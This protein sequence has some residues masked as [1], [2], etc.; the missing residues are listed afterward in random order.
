MANDE[1]FAGIEAFFH[2]A[3]ATSF[4]TAADELGVSTAAV[5]QAVKRLE[6]RVGVKLLARTSRRVVLTP[7]GAKYEERCREAIRL[8]QSARAELSQARRQP[9]GELRVTASLIL[10]PV[11]VPELATLATRYPKLSLRVTLH[12]RVARLLD[13]SID[14]A[15]RVGARTDSTLVSRR[16][17]SPRWVTVASPSFLAR[18][19][20]P[21]APSELER[22]NCLRFVAPNGKPRNFS[23]R[24]PRTLEVTV[25]AVKGNLELDHG[26][27]LL[28]AALAGQGVIQVL[29][30]MARPWLG[31]GRLGE[32][33]ADHAS[34]GPGVFAVTAPER[35]RSP[36][37]RAFVELLAEAF[38]RLAGGGVGVGSSTAR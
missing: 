4:R 35:Q 9:S 3:R 1:L 5:S 25:V 29:D 19:G 26:G 18:H 36:N 37:V 33:L 16:L 8:M 14:V 22:Y 2:V 11:I 23:F 38:E 28:D 24:D 30:F 21:S 15:V 7:E 20:V 27:H 13:E 10:G 12:D 31:A 17:L 6:E 34:E 32:V